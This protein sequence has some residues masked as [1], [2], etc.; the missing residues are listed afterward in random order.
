[1]NLNYEQIVSDSQERELPDLIRRSIEI[2]SAPGNALALIGMRRSGKTWLCFQM[3]K[4]LLDGGTPR[5]NILYVNFEDERLV[6]FSSENFDPLLEV[7]RQRVHD[8]DKKYYVFFD[9]IQEVSGWEK[10]IRR[11]LDEGGFEVTITGSSAK[12]LSAEIHT[13]LRGRALPVEVFPFSLVEF[14]LSKGVEVPDKQP[15]A[16]LKAKLQVCC[17][18]YL[19]SGGFPGVIQLD[20]SSK[21]QM[22]QQYL[23]VVILRDVIERHEVSSVVSLRAFVQHLVHSPSCRMSINKIYNDFKSRGLVCSKNSL[24]AFVDY[25]SD[26]YL[27]FPISIHTRSE[28]VR[29]VNPQKVYLIDTGLLSAASLNITADRGA[30]L[31]NLIFLHLRRRRMVI[32]YFY[33]HGGVETDF[34]VRDPLSGAILDLIQVT[35]SLEDPKTYK[36]E[37]NGLLAA[38]DKLDV[39]HGTIVVWNNYGNTEQVEG[40]RIIS[41]WSYLLELETWE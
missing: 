19:Y 8:S 34:V 15:G 16:K 21:S 4:D 9:E 18:T 28:R 7:F 6:S 32:E 26:A 37:L 17:E 24:H 1:M 13:S 27:I 5:Q 25:L 23:D 20:P 38:M 2:P 39:H 11:I 29:K 22:L 41:A 30:F 3:M 36:R 33:D 10:F 14:A 40:I 35:W 31:E 12:L